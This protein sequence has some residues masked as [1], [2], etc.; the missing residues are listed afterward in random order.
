MHDILHTGSSAGFYLLRLVPWK[1]PR[2]PLFPATPFGGLSLSSRLQNVH[3]H[4]AHPG[5]S[6]GQNTA[7]DPSWLGLVQICEKNAGRQAGLGPAG[8]RGYTVVRGRPTCL[9]RATVRPLAGGFFTTTPSP[10]DWTGKRNKKSKPGSPERCRKERKP[11]GCYDDGVL[12]PNL[13]RAMISILR[14]EFPYPCLK[15]CWG[16]EGERGEVI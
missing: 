8:H 13:H 10:P 4:L 12:A 5:I 15:A 16:G 3:Q 6:P 11:G 9:L 14:G 7:V 2:S 1:P